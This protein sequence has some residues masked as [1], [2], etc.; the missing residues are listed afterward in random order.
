MHGEDT[1]ASQAYFFRLTARG[2]TFASRD[3]MMRCGSETPLVSITFRGDA[4]G[5]GLCGGDGPVIR[6]HGPN[7]FNT[8]ILKRMAHATETEHTDSILKPISGHKQ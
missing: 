1:G 3:L 5:R 7:C 8:Y 4:G 2:L 6:S